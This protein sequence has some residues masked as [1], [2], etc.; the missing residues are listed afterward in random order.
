MTYNDNIKNSIYKWRGTHKEQFNAYCASLMKKQYLK[1]K[2]EKN[3]KNL[4]RYYFKKECQRLSNI[5]IDL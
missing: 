4:E 2:D 5:L 3:K 1:N